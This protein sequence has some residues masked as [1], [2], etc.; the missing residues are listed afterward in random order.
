MWVQDA[1]RKNTSRWIA[2]WKQDQLG[3]LVL[4]GFLPPFALIP[5]IYDKSADLPN[6]LTPVQ[7]RLPVPQEWQTRADACECNGSSKILAIPTTDTSTASATQSR[8]REHDATSCS[9]HQLCHQLQIWLRHTTLT[10]ASCFSKT[11]IQQDMT[12]HVVSTQIAFPSQVAVKNLRETQAALRSQLDPY[13][14]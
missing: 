1:L 7:S 4:S 5:T 8:D 10:R 9:S 13:D 6:V 14:Q 2:F 3:Q 11:W 12:I